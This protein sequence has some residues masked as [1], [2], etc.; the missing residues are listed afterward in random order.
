MRIT[1]DTNLHLDI[2]IIAEDGISAQSDVEQNAP[3]TPLHH[4]RAHP[5]SP[6]LLKTQRNFLRPTRTI[7]K[8]GRWLVVLFPNPTNRNPSTET[9]PQPH[10]TTRSELQ[11][12][13]SSHFRSLS[14]PSTTLDRA[15]DHYKTHTNRDVNDHG[16]LELDLSLLPTTSLIELYEII[17]APN[18]KPESRQSQSAVRVGDSEASPAAAAALLECF[19]RRRPESD[20]NSER[21]VL[22]DFKSTDPATLSIIR[23]DAVEVVK[24][25]D[26]RGLGWCLV[27]N[28]TG[29]KGWV[30]ISH[31]EPEI[32]D[33]DDW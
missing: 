1:E 14:L 31:L 9:S 29:V 21:R 4:H 25:E 12:S 13:I 30:P 33:E 3:L 19:P 28:K 7:I 10:D 11:I 17:R 20:P 16:E 2:F 32:L 6:D 8:N 23:G 27:R 5:V 18:P 26:K 15:I 22:Y 24:K